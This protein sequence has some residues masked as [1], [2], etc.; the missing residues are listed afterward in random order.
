[1][2]LAITGA[3][4]RVG[5]FIVEEALAAGDHVVSMT[6]TPPDHGAFSGPVSRI[7]YDLAGQPP[8]LVGCDVLV[9]CAFQHV[10]GRYR[11][12][13]GKD[14][15]GFRCANLDGTLRLFDAARRDGVRRILFLS[16]RAVYGDHPPGTRLDEDLPPRPDTLYGELKLEAEQALAALNGP[17]CATASLRATG[18]YGPAGPGQRHKWAQLFE[19]FRDGHPIEPRVASE[20]HGADLA[21]AIRLLL[22][23]PAP[24]LAGRSYNLSDILL[25]RHDLLASVAALTGIPSPLPGRADA[26]KVSVMSCTR[27]RSLGWQPGGFVRLR[28]CLPGLLPKIQHESFQ[29]GTN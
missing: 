18:I 27:L 16:S 19:D 3:T 10:P 17:G 26:S 21:A 24:V 23:V 6:R 7:A 29:S 5:R 8:A 12:G 15:E 1:M 4:G 9:H 25:D 11:G 28:E 2:R 22:E 20:V 13:E 14:P